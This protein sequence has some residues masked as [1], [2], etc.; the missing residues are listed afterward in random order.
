MTNDP[1]YSHQNLY[2]FPYCHESTTN[3]RTALGDVIFQQTKKIRNAAS[4]LACQIRNIGKPSNNAANNAMSEI[5]FQELTEF[6]TNDKELW[7]DFCTNIIEANVVTNNSVFFYL[8]GYISERRSV[9]ETKY[10]KSLRKKIQEDQSAESKLKTSGGLMGRIRSSTESLSAIAL[11][12]FQNMRRKS[13]EQGVHRRD[14]GNKPIQDL[15]CAV[16]CSMSADTKLKNEYFVGSPHNSTSLPITSSRH[17]VTG[18]ISF[19][20][21]LRRSMNHNETNLRCSL[22]REQGTSIESSFSAP[23]RYA[24]LPRRLGVDFDE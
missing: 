7:A 9:L 6:L 23:K 21:C 10:R 24:E 5:S 20:F 16:Q 19:D 4:S 12:A 18:Q 2:N 15:A 17:K 11:A 8:I 22:V 13:L 1:V 14:S 3:T